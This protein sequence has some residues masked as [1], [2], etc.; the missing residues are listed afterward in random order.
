MLQSL[1]EK[2]PGDLGQPQ[3]VARPAIEAVVD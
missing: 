1:G 3:N 2:Q